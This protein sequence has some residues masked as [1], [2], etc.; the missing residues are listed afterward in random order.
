MANAGLD[1]EREDHSFHELLYRRCGTPLALQL[2]E[3]T[4]YV[5]IWREIWGER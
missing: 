1:M 4:W 5:R 3:I 2:L